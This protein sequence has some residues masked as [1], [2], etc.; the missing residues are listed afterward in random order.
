MGNVWVLSAAF[1]MTAPAVFAGNPPGPSKWELWTGGTKLRGAN[2]WKKR[3]EAVDGGE[4]GGGAV[5]PDYAPAALKRLASWGANLVNISHPGVFTERAPYVLEAPVAAGLE[6][7]LA[8]VAAADCFAVVSFRT[9][10]GRNEAGFDQA[11]KNR[12]DNRIWRDAAA[13]D[14]WVA[15]WKWTATKL[16]ANPVV[17]A[18][19]L[20]VEPNANDVVLKLSEPAVFYASHRG[21]KLDWNPLAARL[22][23]AIRSVDADTPILIQPMDHGAAAWAGSLKLPSQPKLLVGVH[24]YEPFEYTHQE[25]GVSTYPGRLPDGSHFDRAWIETSLKPVAGAR[26]ALKVPVAVNELGVKR[27]APGADRYLDDVLG[28]LEGLGMNHAVW[29]W[30]SESPK[31]SYDEFNIRRGTD[32]AA[33]KDAPGNPLEKVLRKYWAK[34]TLRPSSRR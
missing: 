16:K 20:M 14:G 19:D 10:P 11:E 34:N 27:T 15:M 29:L 18:Y 24:H 5:G 33:K 31:I 6:R 23:E 28:G 25:G 26:M 13:Q 1:L 17:V 3:V 4:F 9:G 22:I 8:D 32:P 7:V 30:E 2:V 12:A 21:S